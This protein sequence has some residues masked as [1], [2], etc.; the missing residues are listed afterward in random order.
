MA[1]VDECY[2]SECIKFR[3]VLSP[4]HARF[5]VNGAPTETKESPPPINESSV[6][7][8]Q[9]KPLRGKANFPTPQPLSE[10]E[11]VPELPH[12]VT[13]GIH[14]SRQRDILDDIIDEAKAVKDLVRGASTTC[15]YKCVDQTE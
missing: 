11:P 15:V 6:K 12:E 8:L 1:V 4:T 2:P 9:V 7:S 13:S 10:S 14:P 5:R 3:S